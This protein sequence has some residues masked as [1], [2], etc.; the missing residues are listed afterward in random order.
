MF[1]RLC[2]LT[3]FFAMLMLAGNAFAAKIDPASITNGHVYLFE[4][5]GANVP[6][7]S[8][9]NNTANLIGN[10]Q[11]VDGLNG[12]ALQFDGIDDGVHIPDA[13]DLN[14]STHQNR[15]V[16]AIFKCDDVTK[17]AKQAV[18]DEGGT[19]RGLAIY[20]H[21]GLVYVGGWNLSDY[22]PEW[23]G[24]FLSAPI[25]SNEWHAVAMVLRGGSAGMEDNK[26]EMWMDA[27]LIG[28]GPGAELRS[29]SND[30]GIGYH[31]SQIKYHD[32]NVSATGSYFEG[33][34]DEIWIISAALTISE[35]SP[36]MG[37]PW[38]Y[39]SGPN[40]ADGA[41]HEATWVTLSWT[42][43]DIAASHDVYMGD[44]F[45]DVNE[46]THDSEVFRGNQ[47]TDFYVAGFPGFAYPEGLIPGTTYYWRIDEVNDADPDSPWKSD[48]W[49][50][51]VPSRTAYN[52][53]PS[54]GT[55]YVDPNNLTLTWT[56]GFDAKLHYVYFGDDFDTVSNA[57]VGLPQTDAT[58]TPG[59][60][61]LDKT[62]YWRVDEF[63]GLAMHKGNVWSFTTKP[64][65]S[66]T[67]PDLLCW[68][69][70][71]EGQGT[72]VLDWSGH[73]A[74][75]KFVGSPVWVE[76]Y[77]GGALNFNGVSQS[78]TYNFPDQTWTAYTL[79]VWIKSDVLNQDNNSSMCSTYL[80]TGGGFQLSTMI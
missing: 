63:D 12:K 35:L 16:V 34:V 76:G 36:L 19:T 33:V 21:Q 49:S 28:K 54:D 40:P 61:E 74:D 30:C 8:A 75:G 80:T 32:G 66:I 4:N 17:S 56:P 46:A 53:V 59:P 39:A 55:Q 51:T 3:C 26:F 24:T 15:T 14:L 42:P 52:P 37:E 38:P 27:E 20:I 5:V 2:C 77:D 10:P 72:T 57:V 18:Y 79:A 31:N 60:L 11:V 68:W 48:V 25:N 69:K 67:N 43:G 47:V 41:L 9:N 65:I 22:T 23:T 71:D 78:V 64:A 50:F 7:D 1:K 73:G 45:D 58:Y 62:Y 29:R 44:I 6:D 13:T 70:L